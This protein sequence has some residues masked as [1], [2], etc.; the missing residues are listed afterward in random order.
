MEFYIESSELVN[1]LARVQGIVDKTGTSILSHVLVSTDKEKDQITL[2]ATDTN[3]SLQAS[4]PANIKVEGS[5]AVKAH[6]FFQIARSL[7]DKT[8][9]IKFNARNRI[10]LKS[11]KA[12]FKIAECRNA[13]E[14]PPTKNIQE[15]TKISF[16]EKTLKRLIEETVFSIVDNKRAGL[17]GAHLEFDASKNTLRMI[18]TDGNRLSLS[19]G[20]VEDISNLPADDSLKRLFDRVLVPR[21]ALL[22]LKKLCEDDEMLWTISFGNREANFSRE[23]MSLMVNLIDGQFPD[24]QPVLQSLMSKVDKKEAHIKRKELLDVF[25]RVGI[26]IS[27]TNNA[28]TFDF[29]K[30]DLTLSTTNP[31]YGDFEEQLDVDFDGIP[32]RVAFNLKYFQDIL[33]AVQGDTLQLELGDVLDPCILQLKDRDDCKF[34]IMPMRLN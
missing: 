3:L 2:T 31:D 7:G 21:K 28:V 32:I 20:I 14:F 8:V 26:F 22:E 10:E 19:E 25:R 17:N 23:G 29:T 24:Y 5:V 33:N 1:A 13:D 16:A 11:G 4:Y 9:H 34:V 6:R 27:K 15:G 12:E 30:E 18:T